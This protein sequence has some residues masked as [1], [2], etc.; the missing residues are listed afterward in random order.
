[1]LRGG[2]KIQFDTCIELADF[3]AAAYGK[4]GKMHPA[5]RTFQA[6]R[7]EVNKELDEL[8]KG[9][10]AALSV[11]KQGGRMAVISYHSLEDRIVKNFVRDNSRAGLLMTLTRKPVVPSPD[12]VRKNP[13]SRSA[14]LR[15]AEKI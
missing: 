7:I 13:S 15:G 8:R 6:L 11:L 1:M 3:I 12:E 9:L 2:E 14:K 5:T 10:A 4:R